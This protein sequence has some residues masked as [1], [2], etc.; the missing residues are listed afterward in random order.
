MFELKS[1]GY[2]SI[3]QV[4]GSGREIVVNAES[5]ADGKVQGES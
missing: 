4:K 5:H 2:I 1:E 3:N